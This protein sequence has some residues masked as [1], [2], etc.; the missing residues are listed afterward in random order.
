MSILASK[1]NELSTAFTSL[2]RSWLTESEIESVNEFNQTSGDCCGT[3]NY[4]DAN[5]AII[6]AFSQVFGREVDI[7]SDLDN[8]YCNA[9]W[10]LSRDNKFSPAPDYSARELSN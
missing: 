4:C 6:D 2:I 1:V 9:A 10:R 7:S 3:H 8:D 5:Q